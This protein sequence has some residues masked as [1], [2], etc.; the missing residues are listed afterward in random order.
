M[1]STDLHDGW[2]LR[3]A[4]GPVPTLIAQQ[5]V[6]AQV[7]G[8]VH[9][10]LLAAGL[11]VDPYLG[12]NESDLVWMPRADWRYERELAISPVA[13]DERA[14]LVFDGLDTVATITLGDVVVGRTVN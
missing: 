6:P 3:A 9:T 12:L 1:I 2:T 10:D 11:I 8:S 5:Q 14:D 7:P 13:A 4:G